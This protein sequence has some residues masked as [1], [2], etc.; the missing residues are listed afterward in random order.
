MRIEIFLSS[1]MFELSLKNVSI[2]DEKWVI[3]LTLSTKFKR[4]WKSKKIERRHYAHKLVKS[5]EAIL[6]MSKKLFKISTFKQTLDQ[7]SFYT[8]RFC[9]WCHCKRR[10]V[11]DSRSWSKSRFLNIVDLTSFQWQKSTFET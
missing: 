6:D 10:N 9:I 2:W 8:S 4:S 11:Q 1:M 3:S 5:W 7:N